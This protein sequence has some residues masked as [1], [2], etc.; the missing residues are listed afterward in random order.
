MPPLVQAIPATREAGEQ[1]CNAAKHIEALAD[2]GDQELEKL[3]A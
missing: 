3:L 1:A 2:A